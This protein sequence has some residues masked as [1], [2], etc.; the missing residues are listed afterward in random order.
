[1][2]IGVIIWFLTFTLMSQW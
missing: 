1:M 2:D